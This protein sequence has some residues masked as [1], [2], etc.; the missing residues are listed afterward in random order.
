MV[1]LLLL[2][3]KKAL[4]MSINDATPNISGADDIMAE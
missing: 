1:K 2:M 4:N 3:I